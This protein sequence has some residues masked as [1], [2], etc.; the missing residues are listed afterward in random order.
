MLIHTNVDNSILVTIP[1]NFINNMGDKT[2]NASQVKVLV[3]IRNNPNIRKPE[4]EIACSLDKTSIDNI[5]KTL[6]EKGCIERVRSNKTVYW[7]VDD[8]SLCM[9]YNASNC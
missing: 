9:R 5:I 1:F 7:K 4:L 2:F 6:K 3:K 8:W